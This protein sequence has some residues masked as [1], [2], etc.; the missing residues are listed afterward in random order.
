MTP[1]AIS[2]EID[3]DT[4]ARAYTAADKAHVHVGQGLVL[5]LF[6]DREDMVAFAHRL[7]AAIAPVEAQLSQERLVRDSLGI[8]FEP[9]S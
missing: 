8:T 2:V 1:T 6:G 4:S 3:P 5:H 7:V 9:P